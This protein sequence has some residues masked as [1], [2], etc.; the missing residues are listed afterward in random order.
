MKISYRYWFAKK[1]FMGGCVSM[2]FESALHFLRPQLKAQWH[3]EC[4]SWAWQV[5]TSSACTHSSSLTSCQSCLWWLSAPAGFSLL[6]G[7]WV[8]ECPPAP[9]GSTVACGFS[10]ALN[11]RDLDV[12]TNDL[13]R[14]QSGCHRRWETSSSSS[15]GAPSEILGNSASSITFKSLMSHYCYMM[16]GLL[17]LLLLITHRVW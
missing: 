7:P 8:A 3:Y 5:W 13:R 16:G 10:L 6:R 4:L 15:A 12:V 17:L 1:P 14:S 9:I 11:C 2:P